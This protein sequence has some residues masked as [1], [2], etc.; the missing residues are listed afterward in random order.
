[1][2]NF[3]HRHARMYRQAKRHDVRYH[4]WNE[5]R[6]TI[7]SG[8]RQAKNQISFASNAMEKHCGRRSNHS[9]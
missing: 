2:Q 3:R 6:G 9:R 4:P 8:N 7:A 1:M 5:T